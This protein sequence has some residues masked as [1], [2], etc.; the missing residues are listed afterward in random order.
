MDDMMRV[1]NGNDPNLVDRAGQPDAC[2]LT[3]DDV[4]RSVV[5][6]HV[7]IPSPEEKARILAQLEDVVVERYPELARS[8]G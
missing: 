1:C 4:E 8:L 3:F 2:G 6:P 5:H 7:F